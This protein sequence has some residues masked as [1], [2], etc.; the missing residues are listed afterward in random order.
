[1]AV[2]GESKNFKLAWSYARNDVTF[3]RAIAGLIWAT[4][5]RRRNKTESGVAPAPSPAS[6]PLRCTTLA[7]CPPSCDNERSPGRSW[8]RG[9]A[10][11]Q[12]I[13]SSIAHRR[14]SLP[15]W[16]ADHIRPAITICRYS[17]SKRNSRPA[18]PADRPLG[19][20]SPVNES[21]KHGHHF[22]WELYTVQNRRETRS[23][24]TAPQCRQD[25]AT[26]S[27][28]DHP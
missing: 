7:R 15:Y 13:T 2:V 22:R 10:D 21:A 1:M 6:L 27:F 11:R 18:L 26:Y 9:H 12:V 17:R 8:F 16:P 24:P 20:G 3:L 25:S 4:G 23:L 14:S 5:R 28:Q 19:T